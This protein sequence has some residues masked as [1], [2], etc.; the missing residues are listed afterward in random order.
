MMEQQTVQRI[1]EISEKL[2]EPKWLGEVR[3]ESWK[4]AS[5]LPKVLRYG[6]KV[7]MDIEDISL[8]SVSRESTRSAKYTHEVLGEARV[9]GQPGF[10]KDDT[11]V[12]TVREHLPHLVPIL[13]KNY[14]FAVAS[15]F[16]QQIQFVSIDGKDAYVHLKSEVSADAAD[17][18]IVIARAEASGVIVDETH[19]SGGDYLGRTVVVIGEE[20]SNIS[21]VSK[22]VTGNS[23]VFSNKISRSEKDA[24]VSWYESVGEGDLIKTDTEA[25]LLGEGAHAQV[26]SATEAARSEQLDI[27]N[28]VHHLAD[29]TTSTIRCAGVASGSGKLIYRGLIDMGK[30]VHGVT[31]VQSGKFIIASDAAEID[32]IPSLDIASRDVSCAHALSISYL[33]EGELFYARSRGLRDEAAREL[34]TKGIMNDALGVLEDDIAEFLSVAPSG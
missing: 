27:Y 13:A 21:Y 32:A 19:A 34:M 28:S 26:R 12:K 17:M 30:G 9:M 25:Y 23:R 1:K 10:L 15:A 8:V 24:S 7:G 16:F 33:G 3:L 11:L 22:Y 29:H 2:H 5:K 31:G 18:L 4:L 6:L 20:G 14:P